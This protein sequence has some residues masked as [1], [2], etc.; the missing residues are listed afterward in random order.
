MIHVKLACRQPSRHGTC[1]GDIA[2]GH[3]R[4]D[5]LPLREGQAPSA[6][7]EPLKERF[8]KSSICRPAHTSRQWTFDA[9]GPHCQRTRALRGAR[10]HG[11]ERCPDILAAAELGTLWA[12][13]VLA[14]NSDTICAT[15]TP[16]SRSSWRLPERCMVFRA[17]EATRTWHDGEVKAAD[18]GP[19]ELHYAESNRRQP[20]RLLLPWLRATTHVSPG[21]SLEG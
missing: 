6:R 13:T 3:R 18:G 7:Q 20:P 16:A 8:T 2:G 10:H 17:K 1:Q 9:Q 11:S 21:L 14:A 5:M 12:N 15:G 4:G 19:F